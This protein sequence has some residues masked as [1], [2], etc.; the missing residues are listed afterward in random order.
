[1]KF[2]KAEQKQIEGRF[3]AMYDLL[4]K[5]TWIKGHE[6]KD[7]EGHIVSPVSKEATQFCLVGAY[8]HINGPTEG[9]IAALIALQ[10]LIDTRQLDQYIE[11]VLDGEWVETTGNENTDRARAFTFLASELCMGDS[12]GNS[13]VPRK[14]TIFGWNDHDK[15]KLFEVK[16]ML[17]RA[18]KL[19]AK[20]FA[21]HKA[22]VQY[23]AMVEK[24]D[25]AIGSLKI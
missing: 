23:T 7:D 20:V 16:A 6:A 11:E 14:S 12:G 4:T 25:K 15:R 18:Q 3:D 2:T 22:E 5:D 9:Q 24:M 19:Y 10:I 13:P 17:R 21:A 1:M 8:K